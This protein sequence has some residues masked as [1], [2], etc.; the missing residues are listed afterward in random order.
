MVRVGFIK[1]VRQYINIK[2]QSTVEYILLF[3]VVISLISFVFKSDLYK[4]LFGD[5]GKFSSVYRKEME[6]S[7]T[8]GRPGQKGFQRP[9]YGSGNHDSYQGRFFSAKDPYPSK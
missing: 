8:H 2:G 1:K 5:N 6:Y 9:N 7:Y 3:A 4:G